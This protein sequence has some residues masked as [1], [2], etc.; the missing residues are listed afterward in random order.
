MQF[1]AALIALAFTFI[2]ANAIPVAQQQVTDSPA[3]EAA[4]IDL[5]PET[6]LSGG[7]L[8]SVMTLASELKSSLGNA[9]ASD[10]TLPIPAL[11]VVS[12]H[13]MMRQ[14]IEI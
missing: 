14:S 8:N 9:G 6:L 12:Y 5:T 4:P 10:S 1:K 7:G 2:G 11:P 3:N 13:C